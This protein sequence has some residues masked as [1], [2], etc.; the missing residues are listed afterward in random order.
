MRAGKKKRLA[1]MVGEARVSSCV[2]GVSGPLL[3]ARTSAGPVK[4]MA[5]PMMD[6]AGSVEL[7][8]AARGGRGHCG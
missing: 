6:M 7:V 3:F 5:R 2:R 8:M 1:G 4:G